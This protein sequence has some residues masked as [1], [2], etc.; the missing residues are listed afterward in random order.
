MSFHN[1]FVL[2]LTE[3]DVHWQLLLPTAQVQSGKLRKITAL[4]NRL[5]PILK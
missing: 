1:L 4:V 3:G 5:F 2:S